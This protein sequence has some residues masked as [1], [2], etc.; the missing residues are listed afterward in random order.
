MVCHL[1]LDEANC[2]L[3]MGFETQIHIIIFDEILQQMMVY[4]SIYHY[5]MELVHI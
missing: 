3:D 4:V 5:V 1:A 2:M